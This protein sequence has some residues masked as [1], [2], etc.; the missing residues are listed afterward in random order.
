MA[1]DEVAGGAERI[2]TP[3]GKRTRRRLIDAA[4][5]LF[6]KGGYHD[7][8]VSDISAHA[9]VAHGT[10]YTY[11]E[12]KEDIFREVALDL[13]RRMSARRR[14]D[15]KRPVTF[16]GKLEAANRLY[17]EAYRENALLMTAIETIGQSNEELLAIRREIRVAFVERSSRAIARLQASGEAFGDIDPEYAA[18]ALGSMVDRFGYVWFVLGEQFE[19]DEAVRN[20]TLLWARALGI[21]APDGT[22][23]I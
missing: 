18:S 6:S 13:Q 16:L 21:E 19:M 20:L 1:N 23:V 8:N 15:D 4:S 3:K 9:E 17:L 2:L 10:F 14:S 12:S 5:E 7:I 22:D 11:F